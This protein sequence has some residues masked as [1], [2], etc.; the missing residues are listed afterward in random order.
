M[1]NQMT[2]E[3]FTER[4]A[5]YWIEPWGDDWEAAGTIA[6]AVENSLTRYMAAKGGKSRVDEKLA[7]RPGDFIPRPKWQ[8]RRRQFLSPKETEQQLLAAYGSPRDARGQR[9]K[10]A[11]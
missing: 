2:P 11:R 8:R 3:E 6:A 10:P 5:H 9:R 4:W 7:R 1:L